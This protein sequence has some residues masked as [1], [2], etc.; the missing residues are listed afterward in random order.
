MEE[1]LWIYNL[2]QGVNQEEALGRILLLPVLWLNSVSEL[3]NPTTGEMM[4][5]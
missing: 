5:V 1:L 2:F 4:G 3:E